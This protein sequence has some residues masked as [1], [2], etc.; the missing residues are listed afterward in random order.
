MSNPKVVSLHP[1]RKASTA[2]PPIVNSLRQQA[3]K[4]LLTMV[5]ELFDCT[6]DALFEMADRSQNNADHHMY[7]DSMRQIRLRRGD[8]QTR[9]VDELNYGFE[10]VFTGIGAAD[11]MDAA[12]ADEI[13]LVANDDLEISV[14]I[15]GI[16]SKITSQFSLP[17][18]ELTRR[19]DHI[20]KHTTVNE[21][22]NPLGPQALSEAFAHAIEDVDL[23]IKI[24][25][26]LLK[27]FERMVMQRMA[28]VYEEANRA[29]AEAGVLKDLRRS[30]ANVRNPGGA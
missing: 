14:A 5:K 4:R 30:L 13:G 15:S 11:T 7:F 18:M 23:D 3:R 9:F 16:T 20:A 17:I 27:L 19:L 25:I 2:V 28:P 8:I 29:L 12:D 22:R 1:D 26:I 10:R 6:D 21:R 24:R